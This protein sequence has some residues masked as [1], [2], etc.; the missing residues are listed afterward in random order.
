MPDDAPPEGTL[1]GLPL[2]CNGMGKC[3]MVAADGSHRCACTRGWN[4]RYCEEDG[5]HHSRVDGY[6]KECN[7]HGVCTLDTPTHT[8]FCTC[9]TSH[10]GTYCQTSVAVHV[11]TIIF[12]YV[13]APILVALAIALGIYCIIRRVRSH[14]EI[15]APPESEGSSPAT[16]AHS[17]ATDIVSW[18]GAQPGM[19]NLSTDDAV[20]SESVSHELKKFA[21]NSALLSEEGRPV[22]S[23]S[24]SRRPGETA[25]QASRELDS[26][27]E[28]KAF[29]QQAA[30]KV[31]WRRTYSPTA[32]CLKPGGWAWRPPRHTGYGARPRD[33]RSGVRR[34]QCGNASPPGSPPAHEPSPNHPPPDSPLPV[35]E[36]QSPRLLERPDDTEGT[37]MRPLGTQA[38]KTTQCE[39]ELGESG[40]ASHHVIREAHQQP[41]GDPSGGPRGNAPGNLSTELCYKIVPDF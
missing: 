6:T 18:G 19:D 13:L 31:P 12:G 21:F 17:S 16:P 24:W 36:A 15:D 3:E 30:G 14:K 9:E 29:T 23:P 40:D 26:R 4:G 35:D 7:Q 32:G 22:E 28:S 1:E 27:T 10:F 8:Y 39:H 33:G 41:S 38:P 34:S 20:V 11:V 25:S 5:C 37:E 2:A